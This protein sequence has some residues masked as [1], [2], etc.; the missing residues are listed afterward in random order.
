MAIF[1]EAAVAESSLPGGTLGVPRCFSDNM[2]LQEG[3][4]VPI[5][6]WGREGDTVTVRFQNQ[7]ATTRVK[8]GRWM[9]RLGS[10]KPGKPETLTITSGD[11][12]TGSTI[13][14]NNVLVGEVWLAGG[15]SN[16]EFPLKGS[17]ESSEDIANSANPMIR[18]LNVP[19]AR[20]NLPTN[21]I[22]A[23]WTE[24]NPKTVAG[25]SAVA[26]Y[27]ARDLQKSLHVPVG[28]IES[29]W[30]GTP[31][32][33]WMQREFLYANPNYRTEVFGEWVVAEDK[34]EEA[35]AAYA[36]ARDEAKA[37]GVPFTKKL[38][39]QPWVPGELYNGMIAP[40]VGYAIKGA[41]WY[42]G[43][44]NAGS[45]QEA[46]QYHTLLPD[47]IRDWRSA[48]GEGEFT[49]LIVQLAPFFAIQL[50]PPNNPAMTSWASLREAQLQAT[51]TL[52]NVGMAVITDVGDP[53]NIHPT[54][55]APVG[56]RLA[57]AA[58]GIAYH[59]P[60]EYSG[61]VLKNVKFEEDQAIL[62]FDHVDG[63]LVAHGNNLS[64]FSICGPDRKFYW[65]TAIIKEPDQVIVSH[66]L[67][68]KP[69]A[70]RYGWANYPVVNLWN[71]AGLPASPFRT[72][73]FDIQ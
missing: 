45:P 51:Q 38:P 63:G 31:A 28:I 21:N 12:R 61:P 58:R 1:C 6:G 70:V 36:R 32:E 39:P 47:L 55:K 35:V 9:V 41:L 8:D 52:P 17:F 56:A 24:C 15:Q 22:G 23:D 26:Y 69:V 46:W 2:V 62:T 44:S 65:A 34:Y 19:H 64:G 4:S 13:T 72:D 10:L 29:D 54:Q 30:G 68:P 59:Q 5:W 27:F 25:F 48:W 7:T 49:F 11:A 66:P 33:V 3:T 43:E 18:L 40:L 37:K 67:I 71:K 20:L 42:Q 73:D 16:M 60:I 14:L 57:I 53:S 50:E